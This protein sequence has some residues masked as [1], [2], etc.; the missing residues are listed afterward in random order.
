MSDTIFHK[1]LAG[2]IPSAK[3]YE[4]EQIWRGRR[5]KH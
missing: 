5:K 1:I 2:E 4:D 3:I